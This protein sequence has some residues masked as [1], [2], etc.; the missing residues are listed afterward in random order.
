MKKRNIFEPLVG[1]KAKVTQIKPAACSKNER[2]IYGILSAD[3]ETPT[4]EREKPI[5]QY[6]FL[7]TLVAISFLLLLLRAFQLQII[8]GKENYLAAQENRFREK[9][10]R[11]P[12][13]LFYDRN[14]IA[15][16]KNV[17]SYEIQVVPS[18]LPDNEQARWVIYEKVSKIIKKDPLEI[19]KITESKEEKKN[20]SKNV[21]NYRLRYPLPIPIAKNLDQEVALIFESHKNELRGFEVDINPSREYLD[22]GLLSHVL[23]YVGRISEEE[24]TKNSDYRLTDYIGKNGLEKYYEKTLRGVPG[25]ER[26]EIDS[27]GNIVKSYGK[28]EPIPGRNLVLTI[29][30]ELQKKLNENLTQQLEK[31]KVKKGAAIAVNPQNGEVL[32]LVNIPSYDNNLFAKGITEPEYQ[33]LLQNKDNPLLN[34]VMLGEYPSGSIIKPFIA[35]GAL[36]E[37]IVNEST[38]ILS[39]GGIKVGVWE[40][41]DWKRGGHGV[42]NVIKA[43]AESVN[44]YFYAIGGGYEGIRGLGPEK[45]KFYL[46]KFGFGKPVEIDLGNQATGSIPSPEWK[47]KTKN[48]PWYLGDTYNMSIGQ[49]DVL[50]TPIQMVNALSVLANGGKQYKLHL[51]KKIL[52]SNGEL[53]KE[54]S[55]QLISSELVSDKNINIVRKG[56]RECV[57]SGSCRSL[58]SLNV[59]AAGKTGTAQFGLGNSQKHA[60]FE[61]FAPYEA[62]QIAM[63]ILLEGAGEGSTYAVPVARDTLKWYFS[64]NQK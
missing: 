50:V 2:W 14:N 28:Q 57:I 49:G 17:P 32:A 19:K 58:N 26:L 21:E 40:F 38:K 64:R 7:Y 47:E 23:G 31:A 36:E 41:P 61:V 20:V 18:D 39:T 1:V 33:K 4:I 43:I 6:L 30:F 27:S 11:A 53:I 59:L 37:S 8:D 52:N 51:A 5:K 24:L 35:A 63:V 45:I 46:E 25:K 56:M 22:N 44:T 60:W 12:R 55:P 62:P 29:D 48:E 13:G 15:L 34:R 10:I 42:T 16:A 54:V 3:E 9:V